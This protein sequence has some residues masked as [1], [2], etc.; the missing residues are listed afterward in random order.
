MP[1]NTKNVK[2]P[3]SLQEALEHGWQIDEELTT[4]EFDSSSRRVGFLFLTKPGAGKNADR[5]MIPFL[6]LYST[7]RPHFLGE[8]S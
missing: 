1:R 7:R 4:W 2:A 3:R 8:K 5:L 6:A